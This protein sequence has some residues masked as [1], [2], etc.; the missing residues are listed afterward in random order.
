MTQQFNLRPYQESAVDAAVRFLTSSKKRN[1]IEILPTGAGK[2]LVIAS[3]V[4][5]LDGPSIVFQPSKEILEQNFAKFMAYGYRPAVYSASAGR[6]ELGRG[7]TLATIGSVRR[8]AELFRDARYVIVDECHL[9]NAKGGMYREFFESL[10]E[11]K[12]L[13]LTATPYRLISDGFGG[14]I[15]KFLTRTRPR[16]FQDVVYY[17]QNGELFRDGYLARLEYHEVKGFNRGRLQANSTGAD[18]TDRSV[19]QHFAEINF[20]D[21]VLRV[22][23]R[24]LAIGRKGVLVFT[25]FVEESDYIASRIPDAAIVTAQ[26]HKKERERI[27]ADFKRGIIKVVCNVGVL[28]IG[29]DYPELDTVVLAR[30]TMSLAVYYQQVGRC[31][32]PHPDK[33][34]SMIVDMVGLLQQFG[35]VEDLTLHE[36]SAKW[37][38]ASGNRQLT[39]IYY[40]QKNDGNNHRAP[41][42]T[43]QRASASSQSA[44]LFREGQ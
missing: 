15:L 41:I 1:G 2:S 32:R 29:F 16:V 9:V 26:T 38:V 12:I 28:G 25:R 36:N 24:L 6:R 34:H 23:N 5:E 40:G 3:I 44:G 11:I 33:E 30:P 39:N 19:Q 17:V 13:G 35:K 42:A 10:E 8:K 31:V 37:F 14:S 7:I 18:Y 43:P 22:V 4:K 21:K 20:N 27:L